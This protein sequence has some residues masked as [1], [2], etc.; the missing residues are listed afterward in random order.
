MPDSAP[1][2]P[3]AAGAASASPIWL[4][5]RR[6]TK[7]LRARALSHLVPAL[8]LVGGATAAVA[9]QEAL[10]SL[11]GLEFIIGAAYL[12]LMARELLHL[13]HGHGHPEP[14]AWLEL[15][16][17]GILGLEGYHIGHRHHLAELAG[18]PHRAHILP[19][20]YAALAALYVVLAFGLAR[21]GKRRYLHLH[22]DGFSVRTR[23][24]GKEQAGRWAHLAAVQGVGPASAIFSY[25][26]GQQQQLSFEHLYNGA[27]L[28]NQLVAEAQ[29]QLSQA[30]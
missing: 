17:A 24:L 14:V 10:T 2:R 13:R 29:R 11:L 4:Y 25:T 5:N 20:L 26:N 18:A 16:A 8:V 3:D 12:L 21:L 19:W 1:V 23:L 27:E 22:A 15:A 28:R 30:G 6:Y 7:Q 9:S